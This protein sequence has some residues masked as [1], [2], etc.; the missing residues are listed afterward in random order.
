M[1]AISSIGSDTDGGEGLG[2]RGRGVVSRMSTI[3]PWHPMMRTTH[4]SRVARIRRD[5]VEV[6]AFGTGSGTLVLREANEFIIRCGAH[7]SRDRAD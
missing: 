5:I 6:V 3:E 2:V 4:A 7:D 1:A